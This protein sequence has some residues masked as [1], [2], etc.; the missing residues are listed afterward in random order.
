VW[1]HPVF[2]DNCQSIIGHS[3]KNTTMAVYQ[4]SA[5]FKELKCYY[6]FNFL[7]S[8]RLVPGLISYCVGHFLETNR[9]SIPHAVCVII[10]V[11]KKR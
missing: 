2:R 7:M 3:K 5:H 10:I 8:T 9:F 4:V 1:I 11:I 6:F